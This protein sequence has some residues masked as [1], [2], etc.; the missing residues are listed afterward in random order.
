MIWL[1]DVWWLV[2]CGLCDTMGLEFGAACDVLR[3]VSVL[4]AVLGW[5]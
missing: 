5:F 3:Y 1:V 2:C 4:V